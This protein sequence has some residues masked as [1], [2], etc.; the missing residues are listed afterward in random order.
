MIDITSLYTILSNARQ[1]IE[2]ADL[3]EMA[4]LQVVVASTGAPPLHRVILS[5][6]IFSTNWT[7]SE[8]H[9]DYYR[10]DETIILVWGKNHAG[11]T[12]LSPAGSSSSARPAAQIPARPTMAI[13]PQTVSSSA[14]PTTVTT[15]QPSVS[16]SAHQPPPLQQPAP[17]ST[18]GWVSD[19]NGSQRFWNGERWVWDYEYAEDE[20]KSHSRDSKSKG[21]GKGKGT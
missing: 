20:S 2:I 16:S 21:K 9:K 3:S 14:F 4:A 18:S 6:A 7:W 12:P 11:R 5:E 17:R 8:S 15:Y 13:T 10:Y 1:T 19:E